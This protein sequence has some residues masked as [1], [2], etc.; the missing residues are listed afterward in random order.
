MLQP[1]MILSKKRSDMVQTRRKTAA[2]A[3]DGAVKENKV[4]SPA[5]QTPAKKAKRGRPPK[6]KNETISTPSTSGAADVS[7]SEN[8]ARKNNTEGEAAFL[9]NGSEKISVKTEIEEE[10]EEKNEEKADLINSQA[11]HNSTVETLSKRRSNARL[12]SQEEEEEEDE[13]IDFVPK[14]V[15]TEPIE[16][17]S[18]IHPDDPQ[19]SNMS[20]AEKV[21]PRVDDSTDDI[22]LNIPTSSAAI[23]SQIKEE[24]ED[25]PSEEK[26][27]ATNSNVEESES[28]DIADSESECENDAQSDDDHHNTSSSSIP[29]PDSDPPASAYGGEIHIDVD[30]KLSDIAAESSP[31]DRKEDAVAASPL[32]S[33]SM[34]RPR[35]HFL[36]P[37][38]SSFANDSSCVSPQQPPPPPPPLEPAPVREK[39][40]NGV[41]GVFKM[42]FKRAPTNALLKTSALDQPISSQSQPTSS[43]SSSL[44]SSISEVFLSAPESLTTPSKRS[45]F[46]TTASS[47]LPPPQMVEIPKLSFNTP[48]TTN[49][50]SP[51]SDA[52]E[53]QV[54]PKTV[55]VPFVTPTKLSESEIQALKAKAEKV[56]QDIARRHEVKQKEGKDD[57]RRDDRDRRY[58]KVD[59]DRNEQQLRERQREDD[60][61]RAR[62]RERE[63]TKRHDR[64]RE[65]EKIQRQKE[66]EKR[67]REEEESRRKEEDERKLK[68]SDEAQKEKE[69]RL[70]EEDL[71]I[72]EYKLITECNYTMKKEFKKRTEAL[73][74]ECYR[75][76]GNCS[77]DTCVNRAMLTECPNSCKAKCK[78]QRFTRKKYASVEAFHTGTA[79]GCGL[80]A[81]KDIKP[82]RFIIEYVGD[83]VEREDYEKRK[84]IYAADKKHKHHYLCDS[85]IYTI[86]AT[87]NGN[88][89][90]FV[91]HSCDPNAICEKWS[92]P[93]TKGDIS[94]IGFFAKHHIKAGEEICF[95]YQFV[96]YG[97]D[98]QQCFCGTSKCDGWIGQRPEEF[99]SDEDDDDIVTTRHINMDEEEEEKLDE[100]DNLEPFER[101]ELIN[102]M[103]DDL[104][105]RNKKY[106]KKVITIA[107]RITDHEQREDLLKDIFSADTSLS[108][109][110]FYAQNGMATLMGEWLEADDYS[111]VNL[112]LVQVILQTLHNDVFLSC[113]KANNFLLEVLSHWIDSSLG[114]WVDLHVVVN[115]LVTCTVDPKNDYE[116]V[117]DS[118]AKEITDNFNRVKEMAFRLKM[119]WFN[120]SVSFKIPKKVRE[121]VK[122]PASRPEESST[123]SQRLEDDRKDYS[124]SSNQR[125]HHSSYSNSSSSYY[126]RESHPRFFNNGNDVHQYR[127]TGYHGSNY[128]A[129]FLPRR[130]E[131]DSYRDR[132]RREGSRR[133]RTRSRSASP[134]SHKR[135]RLNEKD[136]YR[137]RSPAYERRGATPEER[138]PGSQKSA[139]RSLGHPDLQASLHIK[140]A[141]EELEPQPGLMYP[142]Q[143]QPDHNSYHGH[144]GHP[145]LPGHPGHPSHPGHPG[146]L[147]HPSH[148]GHPGHPGYPVSAYPAYGPYDPSYMYH[149]HGPAYYP[150]P[151]PAHPDNVTLAMG[152]FP[153]GNKLRDLYEK[154]DLD[155]L[156]D[157]L[158]KVKEEITILNEEINKK[159]R[160]NNYLINSRRMREVHAALANYEWAV[161]TDPSGQLYYYNK[162]TKEVQWT[163]PSTEQGRV[164]PEVLA[165]AQK[166]FH[167]SAPQDDL[168]IE[169]P[170][171]SEFL[172]KK[173]EC[174]QDSQS[175]VG[176]DLPLKKY[177][178]T[179]VKRISPDSNRDQREGSRHRD[180]TKNGYRDSSSGDV[181]IKQF[182]SALE[183][184]IG[185]VV[186]KHERLQRS[187][188]VN[189]DKTAWLIKLIAKEMYKRESSQSGFDFQLTENTEKKVKNYTKS[190]IDRKL[191]S[192]DLWKGYSGR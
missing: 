33:P 137:G 49:I 66:E 61:R 18:P 105:I 167:S 107:T 5:S 100:L 151:V 140:T 156:T 56:A 82:G 29:L 103:L 13:L 3:Q 110:A 111:L 189:T 102:E 123:S 158:V 35:I 81:L 8:D 91:N 187:R 59:T 99:S 148:L 144:P 177:T 67:K 80:R 76:G 163:S 171:L 27:V 55:P 101:I 69:R 120:R 152:N 28:M 143:E 178:P 73:E 14:V 169:I 139:E 124:A 68:E 154:A 16:P 145:G 122:E 155:Q 116:A 21:M 30:Q 115:S 4:D 165:K 117:G 15:K 77:D 184:C 138:T 131:K 175:H 31:W 98:A 71:K 6:V 133:S 150:T 118:Y 186:A 42:T 90:R 17:T 92:V 46:G 12:K 37:A 164:E 7:M 78:N 109:Q 104:V 72:P 192:N 79:K 53:D 89:S 50:F 25:E 24:V 44:S 134:R 112:K 127:F 174:D 19:P 119:H 36:H 130:S 191:E 108:T 41:S 149:Q 162:E 168:L 34:S 60:E 22:A 39:C 94:R 141:P 132:R 183:A 182:K 114:D 190:L 62:E 20:K 45:N 88:P 166:A 57:R 129:N 159:T 126:D 47:E 65:E 26:L 63:V 188:E 32:S 75:T 54:S 9:F 40:E 1:T 38:Y 146:H 135:R 23:I 153:P 128:K 136:S 83:I 58:K 173:E 97:R 106:A 70:K 121:P 157:R 48:L 74:C 181:R 179:P 172:V 161:A 86:D 176:N 2:A 51:D 185:K 125:H 64:E 84:A 96:N 93:E 160:E 10:E 170:D 113:A 87:V 180:H 95:D 85:G 142:P 11:K 43:V 147:G 52:S